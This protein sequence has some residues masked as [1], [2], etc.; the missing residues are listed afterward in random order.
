[1]SLNELQTAAA[2][3]E[4]VYRRAAKDQQLTDADIQVSGVTGLRAANIYEDGNSAFYYDDATGFTGRVVVNNK[5]DTVYV[6]FRGTDMAGSLKDL[7]AAKVGFE[8][9]SSID[10]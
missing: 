4:Q 8:R 6:V 3:A 9:S 5:D 7:A 1:M 2:L 10:L